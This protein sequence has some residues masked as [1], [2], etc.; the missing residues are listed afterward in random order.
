MIDFYKIKKYCINLE[1]RPDR[2][3]SV[4]REFNKAG[5]NVKFWNAIDG[6][7]CSIPITCAKS[8]EYNV[9]G[10]IGCL[11][12]HIGLIKHAKEHNYEYI[13]IFEDD[14]ALCA[15][16]L[17]RIKIIEKKNLNFDMLYLGGHFEEGKVKATSDKYFFKADAIAGTY[18]YIL[19]NTIYDFILN[20]SSMNLGID[21]FYVEM[22]QKKFECFAFLPFFVDHLDGISDIALGKGVYPLTH[23]HYKNRL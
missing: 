2:K 20:N 6:S 13:C 22:V 10:I 16:F 1:S 5:I 11:M 18:A 3:K 15:D 19:H 14:I 9:V 7:Q 21:Q 8:S 12:S 17:E 23:K 4:S